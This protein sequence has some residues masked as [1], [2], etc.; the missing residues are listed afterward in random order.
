MF[1]EKQ[2]QKRRII[3][4]QA[5]YGCLCLNAFETILFRIA[6]MLL[7]RL[8]VNQYTGIILLYEC[9]EGFDSIKC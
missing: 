3:E 8:I 7:E 5:S 2:F 9:I 4:A 6:G 1:Y